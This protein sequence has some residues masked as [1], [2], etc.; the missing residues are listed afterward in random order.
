MTETK[1]AGILKKAVPHSLPKL[2]DNESKLNVTVTKTETIQGIYL[3]VSSHDQTQIQQS[4]A[5][6]V[7]L[8]KAHDIYNE[9]SKLY[10]IFGP[11]Q[12]SVYKVFL[13]VDK[14]QNIPNKFSLTEI[15]AGKF[16]RFKLQGDKQITIKSAQTLFHNWLPNS[17][18]K[19]TDIVGFETFIN[20][21]STTPYDKLEREFYMPIEPV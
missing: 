15:K 11:H 1:G 2:W 14:N 10:G 21:P 17:G 4:F 3:I 12:H 6:I 16:A 18:Y 19:I 8:A 20:N 7:Q 5:D 9:N 13:S